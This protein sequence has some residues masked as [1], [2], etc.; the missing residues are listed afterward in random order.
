MAERKGGVT[1]TVR[2]HPRAGRNQLY[3]PNHAERV[4]A[5]VT[6]PPA[7]DQAN[8]AVVELL[9]DWLD[10]AKSWVTLVTGHKSREKTFLI[11]GMSEDE[12]AARVESLREDTVG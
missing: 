10:V 1:I 12:L 4:Q 2:V 11:R 8:Q 7:E 5:R 3:L 6:A 9:A